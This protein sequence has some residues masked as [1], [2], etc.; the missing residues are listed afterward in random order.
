MTSESVLRGDDADAPGANDIVRAGA[1]TRR[2]MCA[3]H[4]V[5]FA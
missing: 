4:R 5:P 3:R 2:R 1:R